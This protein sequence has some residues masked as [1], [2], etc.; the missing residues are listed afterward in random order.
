MTDWREIESRVFMTTGRR[1]PVV[2]VRGEGT[3]VW[4][5]KARSTSTSSAARR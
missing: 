5:H 1:M 4:D 3:K 2:V